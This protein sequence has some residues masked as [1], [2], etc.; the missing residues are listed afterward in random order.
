MFRKNIFLESHAE[1]TTFE[2]AGFFHSWIFQYMY[3][4][5][6]PVRHLQINLT[7]VKRPR[8]LSKIRR[9]KKT[10]TESFNSP[11]D[12]AILNQAV[13]Q[14]THTSQISPVP[15]YRANHKD[16]TNQKV[17]PSA[18]VPVNSKKKLKVTAAQSEAKSERCVEMY[19]VFH[20]SYGG[21]HTHARAHIFSHTMARRLVLI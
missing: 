17:K 14:S 20:P 11:E 6:L 16:I 13:D 9:S 5:S 18:V 2:K 7:N 21:T 15:A 4:T 10:R 1:G 19:A 12:M 8:V 3:S